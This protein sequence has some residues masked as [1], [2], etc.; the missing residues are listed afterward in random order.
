MLCSSYY[1]K[2]SDIQENKFFSILADEVTDC[3]TKEQMPLVLR[4]VDSENK[5]NKRFIK[6]IHCDEGVTGKA[7]SDKILNCI[8]GELSLEITNCRGQCYDGAANMVG[9]Y[10]GVAA[11]ILTQNELAIYTHCASHRL[12]LCVASAC[13]LQ[14]VKNMMENMTRIGNF[15][16]TPKRQALLEKMIMEYLSS[17]RH[18]TLIDVFQN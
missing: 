4:Y 5:I 7:L 1:C 2:D 3:S 16:N 12:N 15:F 14:T 18:S 9:K 13:Q 6:F 10:S 11:H 17:N 8:V